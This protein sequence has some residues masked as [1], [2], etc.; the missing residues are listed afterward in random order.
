MRN[1]IKQVRQQKGITQAELA[2]AAGTSQQQI[3]R[4]EAGSQAVKLMLATR[5]A[6]ALEVDLTTL[7]PETKEVFREAERKAQMKPDDIVEDQDALRAWDNAG[8]DIEDTR[9]YVQM[10]TRSGLKKFY[11]ISSSET[12]R[13]RDNLSD[14]DGSAPFFVF[15]SGARTVAVNLREV[16]FIHELFQPYETEWPQDQTPDADLVVYLNNS[17]EPLTFDME[18]SEASAEVVDILFGM[19]QTLVEQDQFV[20]FED[21]NGET[22]FLKATDITLIDAA[23]WTGDASLY[24]DDL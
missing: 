4:I 9:W 2:E 10:G 6:A 21:T 7:F 11:E 13:L 14:P 16:N 22:V 18:P 24:P 15:S 12:N 8:L 23:S 3:Q 20:S 17:T 5:V 19:L 1:R